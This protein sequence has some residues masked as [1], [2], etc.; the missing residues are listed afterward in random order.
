VNMAYPGGV[1]ERAPMQD[2]APKDQGVAGSKFT[3]I[4]A[5]Q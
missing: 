5:S 4:Q 2:G 1:G 3:I